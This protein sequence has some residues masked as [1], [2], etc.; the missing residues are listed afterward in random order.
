MLPVI[1][2]GVAGCKEKESRSK[3]GGVKK[4]GAVFV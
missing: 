3:L 2:Q 1:G 4:M